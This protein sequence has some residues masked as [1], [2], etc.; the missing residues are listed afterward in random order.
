MLQ[1]YWQLPLSQEAHE[2]FT[3]AAPDGL[4]TPSR[5]PQGILNATSFFQACL[6]RYLTVFVGEDED[7]LLDMLDQIFERLELFGMDVA[8]HK[9][10]FVEKYHVV[11]Q[12][13]L[14][15]TGKA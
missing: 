14:A 15:R 3:I 9:C 1:G 12:D 13:V 11:Q 6:P 10:A 2:V 8:A 7:D 5:V 4:F